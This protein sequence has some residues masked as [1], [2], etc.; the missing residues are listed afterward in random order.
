MDLRINGKIALVF[1][2]SKGLGKA[3]AAQLA[4]EGAKVILASRNRE[5]L[6][7][8]KKEIGALDIMVTDLKVETD[9]TRVVNEVSEQ[10]GGVDILVT[11]SGGPTNGLF[12]DIKINDWKDQY[13][14]L[15]LSPI[16]AIHAAL[17]YMKKN[18]WGRILLITS[19]AAKEPIMNLTISNG[20]RAGLM[21]LVKSISNE[22]AANGITINALLP[23][24]TLTERLKELNVNEQKISEQIPARRLGKPEELGSLACFLAS[25]K[26]AYITGQMI[27]C[28]G[29]YLKGH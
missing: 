28:D 24:Y 29:G 3:V 27:A 2:A 20:L 17:P 10:Y 6:E 7:K 8:A 16:E 21:G 4:Q 14:N 18:S 26:A 9:A 11:N 22:V 25:D 15:F 1:G 5:L 19:V 23:G 13:Q 12:Q